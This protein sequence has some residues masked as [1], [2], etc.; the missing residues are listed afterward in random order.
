MKW[1]RQEKKQIK[2]STPHMYGLGYGAAYQQYIA[3]NLLEELDMSGE[4]FLDRKT[5]TLYFWPPDN[6]TNARYAVSI[7]DKPI[8]NQLCKK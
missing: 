5:G 3:M 7:L 8:Q 6:K 4:W 2:L 1:L